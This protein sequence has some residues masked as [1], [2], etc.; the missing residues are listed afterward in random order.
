[1][2]HI[3]ITVKDPLNLLYSSTKCS[4]CIKRLGLGFAKQLTGKRTT[5]NKDHLAVFLFMIEGSL[6]CKET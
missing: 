2:L 6:N 4:K 3:M 1:M 5:F